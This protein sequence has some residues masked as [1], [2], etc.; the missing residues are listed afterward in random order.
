[1]PVSKETYDAVM[2]CYAYRC[3]ECGTLENVELCHRLAKHKWR[4]KKYPLFINSVL[5]L[6]PRCGGLANGCHKKFDAKYSITD[7]EAEMYESFLQGLTKK[8]K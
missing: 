7:R 6:L 3:I 4:V 2:E 8:N 5:N 1:M